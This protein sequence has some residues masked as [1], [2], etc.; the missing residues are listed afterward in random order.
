MIEIVNNNNKEYKSALIIIVIPIIMMIVLSIIMITS[1]VD[2][3]MSITLIEILF[4]GYVLMLAFINYLV[5]LAHSR[6]YTFKIIDQS[7][8]IERIDRK[9]EIH[10]GDVKKVLY[11]IQRDITGSTSYLMIVTKGLKK[12]IF[13]SNYGAKKIDLNQ[14]LELP[15]FENIK[16]TKFSNR[17][18]GEVVIL[19]Y[20]TI[21]LTY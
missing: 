6:H 1:I 17:L 18:I 7:L 4:V 2:K 3:Q 20:S 14:L 15:I 13:L 16:V 12:N 5:N 8:Y 21:F 19:A 9:Y 11:S 10:I